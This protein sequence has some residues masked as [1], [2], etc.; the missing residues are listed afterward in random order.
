[1]FDLVCAGCE[2]LRA[3]V[4]NGFVVAE[5][6]REIFEYLMRGVVM[7]LDIDRNMDGI[8]E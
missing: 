2:F 8:M 1:M 6:F 4:H 7:K 3:G 5:T